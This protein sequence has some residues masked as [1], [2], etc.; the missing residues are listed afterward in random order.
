MVSRL[1]DKLVKLL[2]IAEDQERQ[3]N[4]AGANH[5]KTASGYGFGRIDSSVILSLG[6]QVKKRGWITYSMVGNPQ[7]GSGVL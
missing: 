7:V 3:D 1:D 2:T 5:T 6:A 4:D